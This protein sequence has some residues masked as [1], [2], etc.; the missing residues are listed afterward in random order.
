M[1]HE[2]RKKKV[3]KKY[4]RWSRWYDAFDLG[5]QGKQKVFSVDALRLR[6]G[7]EVL[8]IG[9]GTGAI[10]GLVA[11]AVGPTGK[12][13]AVDLSPK[14]VEVVRKRYSDK[15]GDVIKPEVGD[16]EDLPYVD[17]HFPRILATFA[18]TSFPDP[19]KALAEAY[20]VMKPGGIFSMLDT[21]PPATMAMR[22]KYALLRPMMLLAGSTH[23]ERD[24]IR[25]A[26]EAG[27]KPM[28]ICRFP[29][30][31]VYC[32]TFTK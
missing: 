20:R 23:I 10:L 8:D 16:V 27:F 2:A 19:E 15:Y 21:G 17:H 14:M 28:K 7:D 25:L 26:K 22:I 30:S 4:D 18:I 31:L 11:E 6:K 3:A 24:G 32:A 5:G 13:V 29:G 9:C 12:V 1:D